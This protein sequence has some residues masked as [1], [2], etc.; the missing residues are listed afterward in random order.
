MTGKRCGMD[1]SEEGPCAGRLKPSI[2]LL[3]GQGYVR[4]S[5]LHLHIR[6]ALPMYLRVGLTEPQLNCMYM[7]MHVMC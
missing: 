2:T 7:Y 5:P 3:F 4:P 6:I 1:V